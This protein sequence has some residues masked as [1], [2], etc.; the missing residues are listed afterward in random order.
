MIIIKK[1]LYRY[2]LKK[3]AIFILMA[4]II[5]FTISLSYADYEAWKNGT[6]EGF[7]LTDKLMSFVDS[8]FD[9]SELTSISSQ[10][11]VTFN[12]DSDKIKIA[13]IEIDGLSNAVK[14]VNELMA[15]AATAIVI[16]TFMVDLEKTSVSHIEWNHMT[17]IKKFVAL[18]FALVC[19]GKSLWICEQIANFGSG[20]T[21]AVINKLDADPTISTAIETL[22]KIIYNDCNKEAVIDGVA[23]FDDELAAMFSNIG[24]QLGYF[25]ELL[26]PWLVKKAC[27]V[28]VGFICWGRAVNILILAAL[29]P[30]PFADLVGSHGSVAGEKFVRNMLSISLQGI[31]IILSMFFCTRLIAGVMTNALAV[32]TPTFST[33]ME[34]I[35]NVI[36]ILLVEMGLVTKSSNLT[37]EIAGL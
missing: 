17:L 29:S 25:I 2:D 32:A 35:Y 19:I 9:V 12:F 16:I 13:G 8:I 1:I 3:H 21:T 15:L 7:F 33:I 6:E 23:K 26:L 36:V 4:S 34:S 14:G 24:T 18:G 5:V 37:R 10:V 31:V 30:I 11:N 22:K 27:N 20:M 28:V